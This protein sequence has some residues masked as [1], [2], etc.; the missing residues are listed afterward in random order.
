MATEYTVEKELKADGACRITLRSP[1][2]A[3]MV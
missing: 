1:T 3:T 2:N